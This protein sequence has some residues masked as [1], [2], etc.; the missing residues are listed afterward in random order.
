MGGQYKITGKAY[1]RMVR[2]RRKAPL[3][4]GAVV[5]LVVL[6]TAGWG[7]YH[8]TGDEDGTARACATPT[9]SAQPVAAAPT[10]RPGLPEPS[11]ITV[12]VYNATKQ[13]GLAKR[14][15]D[16]LKSRGFAIGQVANDPLNQ[17]VPGPAVVRHGFPGTSAATV[18]GA[19]VT[20]SQTFD[21]SR[22]DATVDL[23]L[24]DGFQGLAAPEAVTAALAPPPSPAPTAPG[25]C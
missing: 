20:G 21:D 22:A 5:A 7:V 4:I 11:A 1:P 19:H 9:T 24:G 3:I 10:V 6:A 15:S 18:I 16:E 2:R 23:V 25:D 14:I 12:N 8:F 13:Q 17:P